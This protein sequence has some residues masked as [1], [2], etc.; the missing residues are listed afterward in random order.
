VIRLG[1]RSTLDYVTYR[2]ELDRPGGVPAMLS[3]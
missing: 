2:S 3:P 1:G